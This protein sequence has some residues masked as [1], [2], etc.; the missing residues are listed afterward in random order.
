MDPTVSVVLSINHVVSIE[1]D[2]INHIKVKELYQAL[3]G[4]QHF[5]NIK[6]FLVNEGY[7]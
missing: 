3:K 6:I 4:A 2:A 7:I 5:N 1:E